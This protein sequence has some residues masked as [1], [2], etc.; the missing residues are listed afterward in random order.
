MAFLGNSGV[1][2]MTCNLQRNTA[3]H[4]EFRLA[5]HPFLGRSIAA[6]PLWCAVLL[7]LS[8]VVLGASPARSSSPIAIHPENPHYYIYGGQ[9]L[10]LITSAEHYGAMINKD[11]D[12]VAYFD[13][14]KSYGLNSTR[15]YPGAMF[16]PQGKFLPGNTLGPRPWSLI[17]P[18]ARSAQPGYLFCGNKFDLD[19][20]NDEYFARLKDFIAKAGERGIIVE[21]CFFNSQYSDT[22]P[23]S[24]LYHENNIQNVGECSFVDAQTLK[25]P[26][27]V[28]READYVREI[29]QEVN[30]FDNVILEICDEPALFTPFSE[31]G[32][33]VGHL[34][35]V[36]A[37]AEKSLPKKHLIAQE[38]QGPVGG[39]IDFAGNPNLTVI[40]GQY[41]Q[42]G[43]MD[44]MG[45][46]KALDLEY[47][48][49][50][51]IEMNETYYYPL[52]YED[53]KIADSRV[54]AW[55]FLVGG[56]ASFNQLNGVYTAEN[57]TGNTADNLRLLTG[58]KIL[59]DFIYSFD[60]IRM[61]QDRNFTVKGTSPNAICRGI[62]EPGKQYAFYLH[63]STVMGRGHGYRAI[64]GSYVEH[65]EIALPAGAYKL[66][67]VDPATGSVVASEMIQ[68]KGGERE[69]I[70]PSHLVDIALRIKGI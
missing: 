69:F 8:R 6:F 40:V 67:W 35:E 42:A 18:W 34:I 28:A 56:G 32:A 66:D 44:Q 17:V 37:E 9:P 50:K 26:D 38:V 48:H 36:A 62:S 61:K 31:A 4:R 53:D 7:C 10:I 14:L 33:W 55:E 60:F 51:P 21:I 2:A 24:P 23:L 63:H 46:I 41:V 22:W 12:Y 11:F 43:G 68:H 27:V 5:G 13:M 39:P 25:C 19:R 58:L 16:E 30:E 64:P 20:W 3:I 52:D 65:L 47:Q 57:P 1:G 49:N 70:S 45:G 59:R 54:E 29:V 15:I